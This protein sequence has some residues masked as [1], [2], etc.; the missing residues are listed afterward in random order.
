VHHSKIG[1]A[2]ADKGQSRRAKAG[3]SCARCPLYSVRIL[4]YRDFGGESIAIACGEFDWVQH[5]TIVAEE[6]FFDCGAFSLGNA[7]WQCIQGE[8]DEKIDPTCR[9]FFSCVD[10]YRICGT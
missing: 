9:R 1:A 8:K 7:A 6:T 4:P 2:M 3:N 5:H 10:G